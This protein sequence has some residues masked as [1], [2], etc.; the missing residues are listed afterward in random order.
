[1]QP[2]KAFRMVL[3]SVDGAKCE[4]AAYTPQVHLRAQL[5]TAGR[6]AADQERLSALFASRSAV[7]D[8][9]HPATRAYPAFDGIVAAL[10]YL[11]GK[12]DLSA[13]RVLAL[14]WRRGLVVPTSRLAALV[15]LRL[16]GA[17]DPA[18]EFI[19]ACEG[20]PAL[21]GARLSALAAAHG[22]VLRARDDAI[23]ALVSSSD[24]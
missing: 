12:D 7:Y 21:A 4:R 6:S 10:D 2:D 16:R 15:A 9:Q 19:R 11:D 13:E 14:L 1:M 3:A 24:S 8:S 5:R 20:V 17:R 22:G 18:A 23:L